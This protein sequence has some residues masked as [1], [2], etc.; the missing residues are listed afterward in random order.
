[1]SII[2]VSNRVR[3]VLDSRLAFKNTNYLPFMSDGH[4]TRPA[5][6]HR[7]VEMGTEKPQL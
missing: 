5:T 1:M 3:A 6:E 7:V 2:A 4:C